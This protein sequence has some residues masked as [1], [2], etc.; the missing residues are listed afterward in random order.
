MSTTTRI[1]RGA[2]ALAISVL[3]GFLLTLGLAAPANA[4]AITSPGSPISTFDGDTISV[5]G[6]GTPGNRI[7]LAQCNFTS[8]GANGIDCNAA[9]AVAPIVVGVGGT[10]SANIVVNDTFT[11]VSFSGLPSSGGSTDCTIDL[12]Q[13]QASEY[14]TW[15]P[16]GGP[17]DFGSADLAF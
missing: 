6:T 7:A 1:R 13:L 3:G 11:N 17:V 15:P 2:S 12:C 16:S 14:T 9:T 10:W 8:G 5:T 4:A